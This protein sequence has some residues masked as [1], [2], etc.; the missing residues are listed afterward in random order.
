[1]TPLEFKAWFEGYAEGI[2]SKP[3]ENQWLRIKKRVSEID[4]QVTTHT[5]LVDRYRPLWG[6]IWT[7]NVSGLGGTAISGALGSSVSNAA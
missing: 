1:M 2:E 6:P 4:G 3:T 7:C 5:V